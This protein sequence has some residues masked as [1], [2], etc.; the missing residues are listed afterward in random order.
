MTATLDTGETSRHT[1]V[2][3]GT[4]F[5]GTF[6]SSCPIVVHGSIRG[7]VTAPEVTI[8]PLGAIVGMIKT[9][10]LISNGV[11]SGT[12]DA[13]HVLLSGSVRR[14]TV[15]KAEQLELSLQADRGWL[16]VTFGARKHEVPELSEV[17]PPAAAAP[18]SPDESPEK[19][20]SEARPRRSRNK[21]RR[22]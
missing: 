8:A 9:E 13:V 18:L 17:S 10:R 16:E 11:L 15:I 21:P 6:N 1:L 3:E 20:K 22:G 5:D 4:A 2:D 19:L 12:V 7:A 14:D